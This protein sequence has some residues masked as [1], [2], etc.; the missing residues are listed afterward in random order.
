MIFQSF[1]VRKKIDCETEIK[2][3]EMQTIHIFVQ[4]WVPDHLIRSLKDPTFSYG[5]FEWDK[6]IKLSSIMK[7]ALFVRNLSETERNKL[8]QGLQTSAAFTVRR[9]QIL[10]SSAQKKSTQQI[11]G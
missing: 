6:I 9:C 4:T 3:A 2:S 7:Q 1:D 10:L 5:L 8:E 11:D